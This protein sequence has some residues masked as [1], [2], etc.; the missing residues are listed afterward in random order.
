MLR[1]E[2]AQLGH[3][4]GVASE[5]QLRLEPRLESGKAQLLEPL[6]LATRELFVAE[7]AVGRTAPESEPASEQRQSLR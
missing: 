2:R 7:L 3:E 6:G 5:R 1:G 4:V